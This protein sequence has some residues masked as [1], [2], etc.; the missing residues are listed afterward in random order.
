[1][2]GN[3]PMAYNRARNDEPSESFR[4]LMTYPR[5]A[6]GLQRRCFVGPQGVTYE[7]I[8]DYSETAVG[9]LLEGDTLRVPLDSLGE[10][11]WHEVGAM[12]S[13]RLPD[14]HLSAR[15]ALVAR[16]VAQANPIFLLTRYLRSRARFEETVYALNE[17]ILADGFAMGIREFYG[18][19]VADDGTLVTDTLHPDFFAVRE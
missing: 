11:K 14:H 13:N 15:R 17:E 4:L 2:I 10:P 8:C 9:T 16:Q 12:D 5:D 19:T 18:V 7:V 3:A 6:R 1:M